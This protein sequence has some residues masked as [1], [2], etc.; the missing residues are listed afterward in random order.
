[1]PNTHYLNLLVYLNLW[2]GQGTKWAK[3]A[4]CPGARLLEP[5]LQ[6][7]SIGNR[8][9]CPSNAPHIGQYGLDIISTALLGENGRKTDNLSPFLSPSVFEQT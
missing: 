5:L 1:M 9:F 3:W 8:P 4:K 2:G 7:R 6:N